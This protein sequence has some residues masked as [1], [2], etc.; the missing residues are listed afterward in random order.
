[1]EYS[2]AERH[3][4]SK[5]EITRNSDVNVAKVVILIFLMVSHWWFSLVSLKFQRAN[6]TPG[7]LKI[8]IFD[9]VGLGVGP[10]NYISYKL[11]VNAA[12]LWTTFRLSEVIRYLRM[13]VLLSAQ[14]G[15]TISHKYLYS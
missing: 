1:M 6:Q 5:S 7:N 14:A 10:N 13:S 15:P 3:F 12:D 8:Q 11:P 2:A 9:S 4:W